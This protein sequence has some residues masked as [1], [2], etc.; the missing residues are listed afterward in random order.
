MQAGGHFG[1]SMQALTGGHVHCL[2][3]LQIGHIGFCTSP[4]VLT[5]PRPVGMY[6]HLYKFYVDALRM[7]QILKH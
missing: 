4:P 6:L 3:A 2:W 1:S 7:L 5:S